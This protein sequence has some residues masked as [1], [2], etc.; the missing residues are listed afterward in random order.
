MPIMKTCRYCK[1]NISDKE[2]I[3]P[4]C[5]YNFQTDTLTA[6]FVKRAKKEPAGNK[7]KLVGSPVKAFIFWAALIIILCLIFQYRSRLGDLVSQAKNLFNKDKKKEINKSVGLLDVGSLI[8]P[9]RKLNFK[10]K[11]IEG[12]FYD[13][14]DKSYVVINGQLIPE[15]K[16]YGN[17]LIKKINK[18]S[19][20]VIEGGKAQILSVNINN[21]LKK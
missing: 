2:Q 20:E 21:N 9:G 13:P 10:E 11:K 12:I 19:V 15:G 16:N 6:G 4:Y 1:E 17:I 8:M 18:D 5:G 3:C 14:K 7:K